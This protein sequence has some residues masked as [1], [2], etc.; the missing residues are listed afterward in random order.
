MAINKLIGNDGFLSAQ[1][2]GADLVGDGLGD[3][4]DLY[5]GGVGSGA[6]FYEIITVADSTS[7]LTALNAAFRAGDYFYNDG[8]LVLSAGTL[9]TDTVKALPGLFEAEKNTSIKS[10]EITLS[11]DKIDVTTL[12]DDLKTFRAGRSDAS[13]SLTG[14]TEADENIF[15]DRFLT[16]VEGEPDGTSTSLTRAT[17]DPMYFIGVLQK[18]ESVGNK[19]IAIVGRVELEG[20]SY[21]AVD[22]SA[23]EFTS[24]FSP[25][26]SSTMQKVVVNMV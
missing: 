16:R 4:D 26:A 11:K 1:E 13:G 20:F 18:D 3:L 8:S 12:T 6:R 15:S 19:V 2:V 5:A 10:F 14:I 23:Q 17:S 9:V 24:G 25:S 21:G 7:A 22:G